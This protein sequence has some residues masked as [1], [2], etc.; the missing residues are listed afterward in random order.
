MPCVVAA[1]Y[2]CR[3]ARKDDN[4]DEFRVRTVGNSSIKR[5][6]WEEVDDSCCDSVCSD[7][8]DRSRPAKRSPRAKNS[9]KSALDE[10]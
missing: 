6:R 3:E 2:R 4:D 5:M 7:G 10:T 8:V 1:R 9:S